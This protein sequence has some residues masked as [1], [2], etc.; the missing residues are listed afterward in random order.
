MIESI[1]IKALI[2]A[3]GRDLEELDIRSQKPGDIFLLRDNWKKTYFFE[4]L[5]PLRRLV[6]IFPFKLDG[7][8]HKLIKNLEGCYEINELIELGRSVSFGNWYTG[9]IQILKKLEPL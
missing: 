6:N 7:N 5:D 1:K 3:E 2:E 4:I 9:F 8:E